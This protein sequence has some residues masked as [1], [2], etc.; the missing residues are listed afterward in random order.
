MLITTLLSWH[1]NTIS[2]A[3]LQS[4]LAL[5]TPFRVMVCQARNASGCSADLCGAGSGTP[6]LFMAS[7]IGNSLARLQVPQGSPRCTTA[8]PSVQNVPQN[9]RP[10]LSCQINH[11]WQAY[12]H[13]YRWACYGGDVDAILNLQPVAVEGMD[14]IYG[15]EP[16]IRQLSW[17][18]LT[19]CHSTA[20]AYSFCRWPSTNSWWPI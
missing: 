14:G 11:S 5:F 10:T 6:A 13:C 17:N 1:H 15:R 8:T 18:C 19:C 20:S 7:G 16:T 12:H 9:A 4:K 2:I 3:A